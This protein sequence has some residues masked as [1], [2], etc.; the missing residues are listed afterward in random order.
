MARISALPRPLRL[1]SR[2]FGEPTVAIVV[3]FLAPLS[4]FLPQTERQE[5]WGSLAFGSVALFFLATVADVF[6]V[7][8]E[9]GLEVMA[10]E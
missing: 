4:G 3:P 9:A 6:V 8:H 1:H 7:A 2:G 10:S 5:G